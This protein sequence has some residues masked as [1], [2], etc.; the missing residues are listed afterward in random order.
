MTKR[1][2][3]SLEYMRGEKIIPLER[4]GRRK[5]GRKLKELEETEEEEPNGRETKR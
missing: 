1:Y 3:T 2:N 4:E 5:G